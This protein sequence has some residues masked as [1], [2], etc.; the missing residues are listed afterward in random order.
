MKDIRQEFRKLEREFFINKD[1][2][3]LLK[4]RVGQEFSESDLS[5]F[6]SI[7]LPHEFYQEKFHFFGFKISWKLA[8]DDSLMINFFNIQF[9]FYSKI[10]CC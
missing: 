6:Q 5:L 2:F 10:I 4:C 3:K 9:R 8:K 7:N 1:L